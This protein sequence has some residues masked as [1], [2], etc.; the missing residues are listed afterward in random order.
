[1]TLIE[2]LVAMAILGLVIG[3]I[4]SAT[5]TANTAGSTA[6]KNAR[7][8]VLMTAFGESIKNLNYADCAD[9]ARYQTDFDTAEDSLPDDAEDLRTALGATLTV[10]LVTNG[11][12]CPS[13]DSGVQTVKLKVRVHDRTL[14]REVVKRT[15]DPGVIPF[16]FDF[17]YVQRSALND[18][19]V[20]WGL[21]ATGSTSIFQYEWWCEGAWAEVGPSAEP[22]TPPDFVSFLPTDA[23]PECRYT[24]PSTTGVMQTI[25]LRVTEDGTNR[26]AVKA[27]S[28]QLPPTLAPHNPPLARIK[29]VST[30]ECLVASPCPYDVPVQFEDDSQAPVD[31]AIVQWAWIFGDGTPQI[32]CS[33]PSCRHQP[34]TYVGGG[35]YTVTLVVTDSFGATG[36][37]TI[38]V[39]ISGPVINKPIAMAGSSNLAA[40]PAFGVSEQRVNF[41]AA[42]SHAFGVAPGAG[43]PPGGI[44]NYHWDFGYAGQT[45]SGPNLVTPFFVYPA[46]S[47]R[48]TYVVTL[49]VTSTNGTTNFDTVTIVLDPLVPPIGL[50]NSGARKADIPFIRNAYFDFQ[51]TNVPRTAGDTISYEIMISSSGGFCGGLGF[52]TNGRVFPVPSGAAG[53]TQTYRA[54]FS[55]SP[56]AGFNGV[57]S[58]DSYNFRS[59]TLRSNGT[60]NYATP[61]SNP[62][63]LDPEFF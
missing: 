11:V 39:T 60:G 59:R 20:V 1:M 57:C 62:Q 55:S 45:Q 38:N 18:P 63:P 3:G 9:A 53:T 33:S 58:T 46:S 43:S 41:T 37:A 31:A 36:T 49:T 22:T 34:H 10:E 35:T 44:T 32:L 19:L 25:A 5:L 7:L 42:G 28:F 54:Q 48:A 21:T 27:K 30:P 13:V 8:N 14:T 23:V 56:F 26:T 52:G 2:V 16:D 15:P 47:T 40:D 17:N 29:I 6:N 61:W 12:E 51:W 4:L 24:A 50:R